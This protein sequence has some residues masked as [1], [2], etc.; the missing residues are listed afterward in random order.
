MK[1]TKLIKT[2]LI[3]LVC[4]VFCASTA[5]ATMTFTEGDLLMAFR[6]TGN[7]NTY[8]VDLGQASSFRDATGSFTLNVGNIGADLAATFGSNWSTDS[9]V[10][11]SIVGGIVTPGT[12]GDGTVTAPPFNSK[13]VY[14]SMAGNGLSTDTGFST[15]SQSQISTMANAINNSF[16]VAG[17]K[18][19]G[20]A[21]ANSTVGAVISTATSNDYTEF[22]PTSTPNYFGGPTSSTE[23]SALSTGKLDLFRILE[24]NTGATVAAAANGVSQY[25]GFFTINSSGSI[26]FTPEVTAA[27]EPSRFVLLGL[28]LGG[29]LM[30][31]RRKA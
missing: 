12:Y 31:R 13:S 28:G 19:N 22:I 1:L 5:K 10:Y 14:V 6:Q 21:T 7:S 29:L 25:Q 3:A 23:L 26:S 17:Y 27:P 9:T 16:G 30:R 15:L 24:N 8:V 18:T 20:T 2:G 4:G 11:A